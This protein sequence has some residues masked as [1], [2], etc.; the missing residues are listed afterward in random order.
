MAGVAEVAAS[1][2]AATAPSTSLADLPEASRLVVVVID[3]F[4]V[5]SRQAR[6]P[7]VWGKDCPI[8]GEARLNWRDRRR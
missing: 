7:G 2:L 5:V 1:A 4:L 6:L 8:H 3:A